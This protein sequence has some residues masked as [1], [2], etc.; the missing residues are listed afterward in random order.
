MLNNEGGWQDLHKYHDRI[1][2]LVSAKTLNYE[3]K[4][5]NKSTANSYIQIVCTANDKYVLHV[6]PSDRRVMAQRVSNRHTRNVEYFVDLHAKLAQP[7]TSRA[8]YEYLMN[9]VDLKEWHSPVVFDERR[10][11]T[12]FYREIQ[13]ASR[14]QEDLFISG[15][16][17]SSLAKYMKDG[18]VTIGED[19]ANVMIVDTCTKWYELYVEHSKTTGFD[20]PKPLNVFSKYLES[21]L[22]YSKAGITWLITMPSMRRWCTTFS[23]RRISS[24]RTRGSI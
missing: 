24:T 6:T 22:S 8:L 17:N 15:V 16:I 12:D 10:P 18:V 23:L 20:K 21:L 3:P 11:L 5:I 4:H 9:Y 13:C 2:N 7:E 1:K 14:T 19:V